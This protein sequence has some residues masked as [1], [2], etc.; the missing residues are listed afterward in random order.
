MPPAKYAATDS[1]VS[2]TSSTWS[3]IAARASRYGLSE[4][5]LG[6]DDGLPVSLRAVIRRYGHRSFKIKLGE[7][8]RAHV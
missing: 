8:G 6:G 2:V 1:A 5:G 3:S 4:A 7:I